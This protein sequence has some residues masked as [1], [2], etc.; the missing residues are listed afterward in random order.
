MQRPAGQSPTCSSMSDIVLRDTGQTVEI[1]NKSPSYAFKNVPD[2][3]DL[4]SD[5]N[6][7]FPATL[8]LSRLLYYLTF[9]EANVA[10]ISVAPIHL[11]VLNTF[12]PSCSLPCLS[13][14]LAQAV[15]I[16]CCIFGID[17]IRFFPKRNKNFVCFFYLILYVPSTIFQLKRDGS[18]WV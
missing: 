15:S 7:S 17:G 4:C 6:W 16:S 8:L 3:Q 12:P 9:K 14:P 13:K 2:S 11:V 18:S 5:I 10:T 1:T